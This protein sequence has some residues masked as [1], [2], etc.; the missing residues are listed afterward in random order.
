M[1][2][3]ATKEQTRAL[4]FRVKV[5]LCFAVRKETILS[6]ACRIG[7]EIDTTKPALEKQ[8]S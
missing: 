7:T 6:I 3:R 2:V 4:L 1:K 8:S 5:Q